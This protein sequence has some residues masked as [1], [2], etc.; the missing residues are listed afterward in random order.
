MHFEHIATRIPT[1][2]RVDIWSSIC[3]NIGLK[4]KAIN[5]VMAFYK[6]EETD[7][8]YEGVTKWV[9]YHLLKSKLSY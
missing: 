5:R 1:N 8:F 9:I 2:V 6:L 7:Y 3:Y 4:D